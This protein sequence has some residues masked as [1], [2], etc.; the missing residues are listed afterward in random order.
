MLSQNSFARQS[1][2]VKSQVPDHVK[3]ITMYDP[4]H[5]A[6]PNESD[7]SIPILT[8]QFDQTPPDC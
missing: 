1:Y 7:V 5:S 2:T 4:N 3:N 6:L 8:A